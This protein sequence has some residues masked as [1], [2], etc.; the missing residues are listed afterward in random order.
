MLLQGNLQTV[1]DALYNLGIIDPVLDL[2]WT[3][4]MEAM[5][6]HYDELKKAVDVVNIFQGSP[7]E[8]LIKLERFDDKILNYLAMEV[9]REFA[10]FHTREQ[11][12]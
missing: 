2:D 5:N 12:H 4:E 6:D 9:A 10:D 7:S 3:K 8:L 1:F 11:L